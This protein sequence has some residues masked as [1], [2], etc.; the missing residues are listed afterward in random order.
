MEYNAEA[1]KLEE[2]WEKI[3]RTLEIVE[4]YF[5]YYEESFLPDLRQT[6]DDMLIEADSQMFSDEK[7]GSPVGLLNQAWQRFDADFDVYQTGKHGLLKN[8]SKKF[9]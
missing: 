4:D 2:E 1:D 5:G 3:A 9:E 8:F 7:E 6:I